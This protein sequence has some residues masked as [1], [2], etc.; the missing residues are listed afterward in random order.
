[1]ARKP[2]SRT[3]RNYDGVKPTGHQVSEILPDVLKQIGASFEERGD[4]VLA[5]WPE[6]I[7]DKLASMT[8]AV[9]FTNGVLVVRVNNSTLYSLLSQRDKPRILS[10]LRARFPRTKIYNIVFRMG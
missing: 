2:R 4:L 1:M 6:I 8:Q 3:P 9:S 5:T 10:S 7:G